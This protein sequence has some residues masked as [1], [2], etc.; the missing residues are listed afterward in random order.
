MLTLSSVRRS[1]ARFKPRL[2]Y[3]P[4]PHLA[5]PSGGR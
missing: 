1:L 3:E 4:M 5:R 2:P